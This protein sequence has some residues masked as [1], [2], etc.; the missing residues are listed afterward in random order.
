MRAGVSRILNLLGMLLVGTSAVRVLYL[1]ICF[2]F[3]LPTGQRFQV[4]SAVLVL[5]LLGLSLR[6]LRHDTE[7][8]T[9][10]VSGVTPPKGLL[11]LA[12]CC[13]ALALYLPALGIGLLSDDFVLASRAS[14]WQL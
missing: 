9:T 10:P 11:W 5:V 1:F 2:V 3:R 6:L 13:V 14:H 4:E 7:S 12:S 8:R